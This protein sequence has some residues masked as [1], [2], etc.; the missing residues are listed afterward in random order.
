[1]IQVGFRASLRAVAIMLGLGAG[2]VNAGAVESQIQSLIA[3]YDP[4]QAAARS[5]Q[6]DASVFVPQFYK[7]RNFAPAWYGTP[8]A[9]D[10]FDALNQGVAQ[11]F[12]AQDFELSKLA[13]LYLTAQN[14][15]SARD[16]AMFDVT[17]S[18]TAAQ[19]MRYSIYGKVDAAKQDPNWN[20]DPPV[21][22]QNPPAV[23]NAWLNSSGFA[24]L[25]DQIVLQDEQYRNLI[26]ALAKYRELDA[27]G[28][29]PNVADDQTLRPGMIDEAVRDVR[30]RL[31]AEHALNAGQI[32]PPAPETGEDASWVY[33]EGLAQDVRAFQSRHGLEA[34]GIIGRN[35]FVAL[36]RTTAERM[37]QIRLSLERARWVMHGLESRF[38]LVNIAGGRTYYVN[39][40]DVWSTRS[41][42]GSE[43]RQT[44]VFRDAIRYMEINPTWT[45]P[46][47]IFIKDQLPKIRADITYLSNNHFVVKNRDGD[48]IDPFSVDWANKNPPVTL[49]QLPGSHNALGMVKFM[50][51][52]EHAV[53]LHDT[54]ARGLFDRNERNLSSGC[55]RIEYPFEFASFLMEGD[56]QW[57][58]ARLD[59]I[60]ASERTTRIDLPTPVPVLLLYWTAWVEDG[61]VHFREDI[62]ERDADLL[63]ALNR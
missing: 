15:E 43:Y 2:A 4:Q 61:A 48:I 29:W 35:T 55:V 22:E 9:Q 25:M 8:A 37:D 63:E 57:N 33:D 38:V 18:A 7:L 32:L 46:H 1:M 45:V 51:P 30:Y 60:L 54:N 47:S 5:P 36:N 23:V 13:Q 52:N 56:A 16:I 44:P 26:R 12:H 28:G 31:A 14:T 11:G 58:T 10:L 42:T 21:L 19:L 62:Y 39:G 3:T 41:V 17:A 40:A 27:K 53:Y 6:T 50:F 59:D 24:A 20:F 34:D 49:M